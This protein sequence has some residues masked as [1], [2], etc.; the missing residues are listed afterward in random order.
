VNFN[1][2]TFIYEDFR[3]LS[4]VFVQILLFATMCHTSPLFGMYSLCYLLTSHLT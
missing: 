3:V 4:A 2:F 1:T